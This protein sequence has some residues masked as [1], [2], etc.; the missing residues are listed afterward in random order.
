MMV[1]SQT[2]SCDVLII[3]AGLAGLSA[4]LEAQKHGVSIVMLAKGRIGRSGNTPISRGGMAAVLADG[5][6]GDSVSLHIED[7]LRGGACL[8]D[9]KLVSVLAEN[10]DREIGRLAESGV[11]FLKKNNRIVRLGSPGHSRKRFLNMDA[12]YAGLR[13]PDG[14]AITKPL[15]QKVSASGIILLEGVMVIG[16]LGDGHRVAGAY[17]LDRREE[18]AWLFNSSTV[19]LASGGL[20]RLY[21]VTSNAVDATGDGYAQAGQVGADLRDMEFIQFHPAM[22]LVRDHFVWHWNA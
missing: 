15:L 6:D 3:G 11:P 12:S 22:T 21:R 19:I 8:S 13:G 16:L 7:T 4:A 18:K 5:Y 1:K 20:G 2:I 17:G 10:A 9:R 14:L